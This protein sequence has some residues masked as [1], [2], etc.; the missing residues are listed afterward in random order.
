MSSKKTRRSFEAGHFRKFLLIVDEIQSGLG[1]A[2]KFF[3]YMYD[4]ITPDMVRGFMSMMQRGGPG[5][6]RSPERP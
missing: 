3:A 4:Q 5:G 6:M 2:G 1:R